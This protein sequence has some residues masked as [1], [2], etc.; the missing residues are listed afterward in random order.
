VGEQRQ[1]EVSDAKKQVKGLEKQEVD[2]DPKL[3]LCFSREINW[4]PHEIDDTDQSDAYGWK[5]PNDG[6][7]GLI[8]CERCSAAYSKYLTQT[9]REIETQ[10]ASNLG[11]E[12]KEL[13]GFLS[14]A[15]SKL[16]IAADAAKKKAPPT[17]TQAS[18]SFPAARKGGQKVPTTSN[19]FENFD[20]D[21]TNAMDMGT[22]ANVAKL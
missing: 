8:C 1:Q 18:H 10:R 12:V 7:G 4:K 2:P 20:W 9:T 3:P 16:S 19:E 21:V 15:Q 22:D 5:C 13:L 14:D 6:P 17:T 11:Y